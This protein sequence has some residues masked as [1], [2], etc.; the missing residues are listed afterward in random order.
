MTIKIAS[1]E[2]RDLPRT[3]SAIHFLRPAFLAVGGLLIYGAFRNSVPALIAA[4][5]VSTLSV[6]PTLV[7]HGEYRRKQLRRNGNPCG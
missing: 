6:L 4:G 1:P 7:L 5:A 3:S 2:K